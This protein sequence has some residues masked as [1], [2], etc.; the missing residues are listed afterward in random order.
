[1][2]GHIEHGSDFGGLFRYLLAEDKG[3]R[4][5]GGLAAGRTSSELTQE[6]N[7]C[8]DQRRTTKKPVK[9]LIISFA[10]ADGYVTDDV[11]ARI[12]KS[13]VEELGYTYNQ[14]V[15]VDHHRDDPGHDWNHDHDHIHIAVNMITLDGKRVDDWQDKRSF[16]EI[17]RQLEVR[18][19]LTPVV[20]SKQRKRK[21]L[22]HGQTQRIKREIKELKS[23]DQLCWY[24]ERNRTL[25]PE[26]P[27]SI[28]LQA[29]IDKA[30]EDKPDLTTF[31]GR[32][33]HLG[34]DV[35]PTISDKGR[36][37]ISYRL[38]D[39]KVRG[40]KLHNGSF[41]KLIDQRGVDF[42]LKRDGPAMDA[43]VLGQ[44][45]SIPQSK[46]IAWS[47]IDLV[48]YLPSALHN[49]F[50]RAQTKLKQHELQL[51]N[52]VKDEP[53]NQQP[54]KLT[55]SKLLEIKSNVTKWLS[56]RPPE[57][58]QE[59]I[60]GIQTE[61]NRLKRRLASG[62]RRINAQIQ[63]LKQLGSPRSYFN[64]F[65]VSSDIIEQ[66]KTQIRLNQSKL[67][68]IERKLT[69]ANDNLE[70]WQKKVQVY[71]DWHTSPQTQKMNS[72]AQLLLT[73]DIIDRL[74]K[75]EEGFK[76]Y[77]CASYILKQLGTSLGE[78]RRFQGKFYSF[79]KRDKT[80]TIS[81]THDDSII[82]IA[83]Y[84]RDRGGIVE[85]E[86]FD[87]T[88]QD[89]ERLDESVRYLKQQEKPKQRSK[90]FSIG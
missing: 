3:A 50:D 11:K 46:R 44:R 7:N 87:L 27:L 45:V 35:R 63:E 83:S 24:A 31:V 81:R 2:I 5:I 38:E 79:E 66:K 57:P 12:A 70:R 37:R 88:Q 58:R 77:D 43:A 80:L 69:T 22:S 65:G 29:A 41:P 20:S 59:I 33:Q 61:I 17:L 16:E 13:A 47:Q 55:D 21:A 14:Y 39:L 25:I 67:K 76:I 52:N 84:N 68:D 1:M 74:N 4:I 18:E 23:G 78:T 54:T 49:D 19:Q 8:A 90:G 40:S 73:P 42:D 32:L 75:I 53:A 34:I 26:I 30:S 64:P 15:V 86:K 51:S 28:K 85:L 6:F 62:E 48:S 56:S 72:L 82:F 71:Q 10:A 9:H 60:Q 89:K 36:K